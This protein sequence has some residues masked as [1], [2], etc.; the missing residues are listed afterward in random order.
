MPLR[1]KSLP[2]QVTAPLELLN[3]TV[4]NPSLA[5]AVV[6]V[7]V[8]GSK[9]SDGPEERDCT[10]KSI[11]WGASAPS[12]DIPAMAMASGE[13]VAVSPESTGFSKGVEL[14]GV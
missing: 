14:V 6:A 9:G 4:S 10:P 13:K 7:K 11:I 2:F 3:P 5:E 12:S 1:F 8:T